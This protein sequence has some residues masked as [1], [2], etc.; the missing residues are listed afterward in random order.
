MLL[1]Y[2]SKTTLVSIS[3]IQNGKYLI[4]KITDL[5]DYAFRINFMITLNE[6]QKN[7]RSVKYRF[8]VI[9]LTVLSDRNL[10]NKKILK[11]LNYST[12]N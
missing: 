10:T 1:F 6:Y 9:G 11:L 8:F 12:I 4:N 3:L 7:K 2:G 5:R